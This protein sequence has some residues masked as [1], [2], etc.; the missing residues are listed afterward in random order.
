MAVPALR[1]LR[2][3]GNWTRNI[4]IHRGRQQALGVSEMGPGRR[5]PGRAVPRQVPLLAFLLAVLGR[6]GAEQLRYSVA[7]EMPPGS[8][9]GN[10]AKDLGLDVRDL[11]QRKLRISSE[12]P[13][14]SVNG[15]NGDLRVAGR[16]DREGLCG[17]TPLCVLHL[18][19]VAE[20][21][22]HVFHLTVAIQD[23]NDNAPRFPKDS[24]DLEISELE[25]AGAR[26][27]LEPAQDPDVGINSLQNY[28]LSS[29][30][31]FV[32]ELKENPD[33]EKYAE[34]VLE[35]P[36]DRE[37]GG[38]LR[39]TLSALDGGDPVQT[40]TVS[41]Q[42]DVLDANDNP[43]VFSDQM[44]KVS[45]RENRPQGALVLHVTATDADEGANAQ[46]TYSFSSLP[47]SARRL[48][49]LDPASGRI[50]TQGVLDFELK[51]SYTLGVEARDGGG[52]TGHCK[53][54]VEVLDENDNAPEV[55]LTSVFSPIPEDSA[56]GT[57]IALLK[58]RDP[59]DGAN[60]EVTCR[61]Q[62]DL[63][64]KIVSSSKHYYKVL[65]DGPLDRER[66]PQYNISITARD[67]G[68]PPLSAHTSILLQVSDVNDNAPVF[69]EAS[70]TAYVG[71]NN[72]SGASILR[73]SASDRD[74]ERNARVTYSIVRSSVAEGP[75]WSYVSLNAQS[76]A[77]Y[78]QRSFDYEQLRAFEL[79]VQA[80]DGGSPAL[81]SNVSV[82][83]FIVDRNDNAPRI[84]YPPAGSGSGSGSLE[85]V[86]RSSEAGYL[87]SKVVAVDAD[88]GHNAWLSYHVVQATDPSLFRV[89]LHSGEVRTARAVSERDAAKQRVVAL[90]K[91][92]GQPP[93]SATVTVSLVLAENLQ[94]AVPEMRERAGESGPE[95][96]LQFYL[97]LA[98]ALISFV[99]LLT[100]ALAVAM[101]VRS[102]RSPRLLQ[103]FGPEPYSKSGSMFPPNYE[104]GTLPYSYQL[105]LSSDLKSN[106]CTFRKPSAR[107][108]EKVV[109]GENCGTFLMSNGCSV[110]KSEAETAE[111]KL[112]Q[113]PAS[114][115]PLQ[116]SKA[117][118][119][120][121][122]C[123]LGHFC[124]PERFQAPSAAE[125]RAMETAVEPGRR[126]PGRALPRQVPLL[127]FV[128]AVLGRAGAEQLRYSV[129][130]EM[131]PGSLVG[132]LAKDLGLDVRDLPQ[133]KLRISSEQPHL[134]VNGDTGDL[135]VAGRIDREGLCGETPLC[136][137]ALE[138]VVEKPL[139]VFHVTVAIRDINDNAPRFLQ[140][141][142][143]LEIN[144]LAPPGARFQ[145]EPAQDPDAGSNSVQRYQLS[146]DPHFTL[147]VKESPD[148]TKYP[149]LVLEKALDREK[150]SS[151][152]LVLTAVDG[153]DPAR[154]GTAQIRVN[155]TDANDNAPE[156]TEEIYTASV[157]E[158]LPPGSLVLQVTATDRDEGSHAQITYSFS[159]TPGNARAVF[160]LDPESGRITNRGELDFEN[161]QKYALRVEARDAGGQTAQ[162]KVHITILDEN[163]NAP[164]MAFTSVFSPIPEDSVPGTVI[165]LLK[166]R[167]QD[168]GKNGQVTCH[169]QRNLPFKIVSSSK[170]YYKVLTDW[171]LDRERTPQYNISITARDG[172]SPPLSAHTNI[173]LQVSDVNDNAPV[174]AEAS[175]T[176]Y[177]GENN[178]SGASILRVSA[179]DGDAERNARVTYSI[180][181]SS[182]AEGPV[183]SYVS[184]NA[185]SGAVYA[186][187]SF[188][189]EQLRAF[190]LQVQAA[191]GGSPALSSNVSVR[192]FIVDRNDNA[193][194]ILYPPAGSGSGAESGSLELVPRSSEAGYLVSK[195]VAVDA[196]SGHNAWLSYHV[197]QATDPSLFRVGLHSGEVRTARAVSER[198]AAKQRVVALV[199]DN[200]QP[201]LSATVTVSL[202]LAENL[203]EAVP[204]MR[205]R[206]G[207]SGPEAALQFYL[208]LA[209]A[210]IS[211]VFLL[212]VALAVAMKVRSWRSPRLLQCFGPEPYSKSGSMFPPNYEDGTLPYSYQ[213]CLSSDLKSNKCTFRKPSAQDVENILCV[214]SA[215]MSFTGNGCVSVR[216][217]TDAAGEQAQPNPDWRFSQAQRPGT[218]GSQNGEEGGTW[219]N[220]QFDT[221]MLQA[222][223]LASAN[224]AAD[225]NSTLG[226]GAGT[227]GLS[228]RYGPQFTLQHVPDYRQNVYI[229]GSTATLSNSSG[230][231]DGK[232]SGSSGGNKK[233]SGKKEKK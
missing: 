61:V 56:P 3:D 210:L 14:L 11:P 195:V 20:N 172:G 109:E 51:S 88:S 75:V 29:N 39:L 164:E 86:P 215:G 106:K 156:F 73:V 153:G 182:V 187:R 70:Y 30:P 13:H 201:P 181:R 143:D 159:N 50:T 59:D 129:A 53:V 148:G 218:S 26:F 85:L 125:Q 120:C 178:P 62:D 197:V 123:G 231:R 37:R 183:W 186:Q 57:V 220:N 163:D 224:E 34:L 206:A 176:A 160:H 202:V 189:Y 188:D 230:K 82:R 200:G 19:V 111:A 90:V 213:L 128:L 77:V 126:E 99:F 68:S 227:M 205:E 76:G 208:V 87:V 10:L 48:F 152:H 79:Q 115:R 118:G 119:L 221:E 173:L 22:L 42:I 207:E 89:G 18:E 12:Q 105:C 217:E 211:F 137:L 107:M 41:I 72:P 80:A 149:E 65:T 177:V 155:V 116:P 45:L 93:L 71:E 165:A 112:L 158:N 141:S 121:A 44:Y 32:L 16:I 43:P 135:R 130:E 229:P 103:C 184:L 1:S 81:S 60:G 228:T 185:Q 54:Q 136:A 194:R 97:V 169:I 139:N 142:T 95:A 209:L 144:E 223:I 25:R 117:P 222:M 2:A 175:Y 190:E 63:P 147:A 124:S 157:S 69:A 92:N 58:A 180:V 131:P 101:K 104:D 138:A 31:Y 192:V 145:L 198:D 24:I 52:L 174:F 78:A 168:T 21:P 33:G 167:D 9:V 113:S 114:E 150:Q 170:H 225:G 100:V 219:P 191:D 108:G 110:L 204:E 193:P 214:D 166:V 17:E 203:Q 91:D 6:A 127:A 7:E 64:F 96:A 133:R 23:I 151:H 102:W 212:T 35:K 232:S 171:P 84:L 122:L 140:S 4:R 47:Q 66:T 196:D 74:A 233:K 146:Q 46:I 28:Q 162:C 199:K 36:L 55:T 8:L 5:E 27:P 216:A 179:S 154:S 67:G 226:G 83:V 15:D 38:S 132:N 134:S 40:G 161:T 98:L 49:A 94:E